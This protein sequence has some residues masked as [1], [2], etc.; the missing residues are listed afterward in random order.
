MSIRHRHRHRHRLIE[1]YL[2]WT[3]LHV[4]SGTLY[5]DSHSLTLEIFFRNLWSLWAS[6][7]ALVMAL[8]MV[9]VVEIE[10]PLLVKRSSKCGDSNNPLK[11]IVSLTNQETEEHQTQDHIYVGHYLLGD[12]FGRDVAVSR[13]GR[14]GDDPVHGAVPLLRL[15]RV[16][17]VHPG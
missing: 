13:R 5:S 17:E 2:T 16:Y 6:P 9:P 11:L 1:F 14:G 8:L 7:L 3:S 12:G 10:R 15:G 4:S